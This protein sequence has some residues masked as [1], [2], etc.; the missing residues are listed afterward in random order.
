MKQYEI[1][2]RKTTHEIEVVVRNL[3]FRES[4][5][6]KSSMILEPSEAHTLL[7]KELYPEENQ[8]ALHSKIGSWVTKTVHEKAENELT[9]ESSVDAVAGL[10]ISIGTTPEMELSNEAFAILTMYRML[11]EMD[12]EL[13]SDFDAMKNEEVEYIIV[14]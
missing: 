1:R 6:V 9:L 13:L 4:I 10:A 2:L 12:S 3:K 5:I 8:L 14:S 7:E 11:S